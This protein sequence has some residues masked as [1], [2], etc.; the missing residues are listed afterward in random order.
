M[1]IIDNWGVDLW[2]CH[3]F[4]NNMTNVF[5]WTKIIYSHFKFLQWPTQLYTCESVAVRSS[6]VKHNLVWYWL[7]HQSEQL[8]RAADIKFC[9]E[10][11]RSHLLHCPRGPKLV[12]HVS[13]PVPVHPTLHLSH[14][15]WGPN[16]GAHW[17]QFSPIQPLVQL[18]HCQSSGHS[19]CTLVL[20][21]GSICCILHQSSLSC[22]LYTVVDLC[23]SSFLEREKGNC[24]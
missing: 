5:F 15:S 10:N 6:E 17:A 4:W 19:Q 23:N 7:V 13:Q 2:Q 11:P 18:S 8:I 21:N 3:F 16:F 20:P 14:W 12:S 1:H 24:H 9:P 22:I